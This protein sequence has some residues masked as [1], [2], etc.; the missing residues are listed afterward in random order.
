VPLINNNV[1]G[2]GRKVAAVLAGLAAASVVLSAVA[3]ADPDPG[4]DPGPGPGPGPSAD[5]NADLGAAADAGAPVVDLKAQCE[6]PEVGGVFVT[7]PGQVT[8]SECQYIVEGYFY[9]DNY[10]NG[11]YTGTLVYRDGA[12]VPT[13]RPQLPELLT[14]IPSDKPLI[15]P[16]QL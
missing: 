2:R 8:H 9:Y 11:A 7:A 15:F 4:P 5:A 10:D 1:I 16:G 12:K 14:A 13:E 3:L 6:S